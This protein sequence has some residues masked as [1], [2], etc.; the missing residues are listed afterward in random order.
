MGSGI[1]YINL[2]PWGDFLG[3]Q[4]LTSDTAQMD[5]SNIP[6]GYKWLLVLISAE[7]EAGK[8]GTTCFIRFNNDSVANH[9]NFLKSYSEAGSVF[10]TASVTSSALYGQ[11]LTSARFSTSQVVVSNVPVTAYKG[12]WLTGGDEFQVFTTA[13]S[14]A[15]Q[16][17]EINQV[18][19]LTASGD[20]FKAGSQVFI[21]GVR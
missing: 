17:D 15:N 14:W 18:T 3:Q 9:Y 8:P 11:N 1:N 13:G 21:Y 5:V 20:K 2:H 19:L 7:L 12:Y 16:T 4:I 6:A 10:I